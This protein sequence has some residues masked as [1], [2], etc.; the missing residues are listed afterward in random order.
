MGLLREARA[1]GRARKG[2]KHGW[3]TSRVQRSVLVAAM[4]VVGCKAAP[5][6][7]GVA[8]G[9]AF[10]PRDSHPLSH[11]QISAEPSRPAG[12]QRGLH[13]PPRAPR[14]VVT[15]VYHHT[16]VIDPYRWMETQ[17][18]EFESWLTAQNR[19]AR[20]LL[21][22]ITGHARLRAELQEA[23]RSVDNLDIIG[24]VGVQPRVFG[25]RR[26]ASDETAKLVFRD[27]WNGPDRVLVDPSRPRAGA[28]KNSA[29]V[30]IDDVYP[31]PDGRYV[32]YTVS[33][34]GSENATIE[35]VDVESGRVLPDRID[36]TQQPDISWRP[37]GR[38]FFY[39]RRAKPMRNAR[40]S[41]WYKNSATYLHT[42]GDDPDKA[43]PVIS[44]TPD[45]GLSSDD[46][47]LVRVTPASR[48]AL[49]EGRSGPSDPMYFVAAL[50]SV[51]P[52]AAHW[53][54]VATAS[55]KVRGMLVHGDRLFAL[56][57]SGAPNFRIA[58]LDARSGSLAAA[59]DF[60]PESD[61]VLVDFAGARDAMYVV[62]LD[63]GRHR[64]LRI[65]W[66][67]GA[68]AAISLPFTGSIGK[69]VASPSRDGL[70]FSLEGWTQPQ[71][72]YRFDLRAGVTELEHVSSS[73]DGRDF[74]AEEATA[75][76]RDYTEV[77][78]S[79]VRRRDR[80]LDGSA[81]ALLS[82]Y[83]AYGVTTTPFYDPITMTWIRRGGVYSVCHVR[84][85]G[86]RGK[87]WHLA[88]IKENKENGVD[89]FI[90]CAEY[91]FRKG[92]TSARRLTATGTSGGGLLVGGAITKRP[93]L[94]S[95]AVLR[96]PL[97]NPLRNETT[98]GG[99][100]NAHEFGT[101]A[102]ESEFRSLLASDPFHRVRDGRD[103]PAVLLTAGLH[104]QR[105]PPWQPAKFAARLQAASSSKPTLLR[106]EFDAGHGYGSTA[107]QREDEFADIYAFALWQSGIPLGR[108]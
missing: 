15:D 101:V 7:P 23:N 46:T 73:P 24:I 81:A 6:N 95:A 25:L 8:R 82:A 10:I 61:L 56:T 94:F 19:Y 47:T 87:S 57:Y 32:A 103:Y 48:W 97:V 28:S 17:S 49:A 62:T 80:S 104:D 64:L 11:S 27:G 71:R 14:R 41:D 13:P 65:P 98:Q 34:G 108:Q 63:L 21:G 36:R 90:A 60:V 96:V 74:I 26:R 102:V 22:A 77:P 68:R 30:A 83:G 20:R 3:P 4:A 43:I 40:P 91:L 44:T 29:H 86:A 93:E 84:G 75:I 72:W 89:D 76:S 55:D 92:Y 33:E 38:S 54:T 100:A 12:P 50:A 88:G 37:D 70:V 31:S 35:L 107:T 1:W 9:P 16:R 105:I 18:P 59:R 79:I 58:S 69:L 5:P 78:L 52:G 106:V 51:R 99:P 66:G 67:N 45:L 39:W 2:T 53:R 85:G 42:I